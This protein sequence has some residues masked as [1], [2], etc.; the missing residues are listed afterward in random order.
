[1][2]VR[3]TTSLWPQRLTRPDAADLHRAAAATDDALFDLTTD[4]AIG[5]SEDS[6]REVATFSNPAV[7][8]LVDE[9]KG[10]HT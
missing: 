9:T 10:V 5:D 2:A 1:M 7:T 4:G 8:N 3:V 6:M